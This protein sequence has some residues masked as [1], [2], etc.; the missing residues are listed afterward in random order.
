M[1][2]VLNNDAICAADEGFQVVGAS[3]VP[4]D[5]QTADLWHTFT[6]IENRSAIARL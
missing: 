2:G 3:R 5:E 6:S 4:T 1:L